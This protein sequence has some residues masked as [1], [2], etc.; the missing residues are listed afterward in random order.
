VSPGQ[1]GAG[2]GAV[3][4]TGLAT[5]RMRTGRRGRAALGFIGAIVL[6]LIAADL[7]SVLPD[8]EEAVGDAGDSLGAWAYPLMAAMAFFETTIPPLTL[9]F[10]GEWVILFGGAMAG[11]GSLAIVPLMLIVWACSAAGDSVCF[12]LGR[13][14]GQ[15]F[16]HR[17]GRRLGLTEAR[18]GRLDDWLDHYGPPAV[19]FGRLLPLARPFG[20]FIAGASHFPYRRFLPWSVLGTLLFTL[21]FCGLGYVFYSSYDEVAAKLGRGAL[22]LLVLIVVAI[23]GVRSLRRRRAASRTG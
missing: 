7:G 21:V 3:A 14:L 8:G 20:P 10:P 17:Y 6:A 22:V 18:L 4:L 2:V 23:L 15:P 11:E 19:C 9:I 12:G 13:R 16:L 5:W 1:I